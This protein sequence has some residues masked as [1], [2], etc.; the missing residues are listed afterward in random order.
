M[1]EKQIINKL[2]QQILVLM[3]KLLNSHV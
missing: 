3:L 2:E 1:K